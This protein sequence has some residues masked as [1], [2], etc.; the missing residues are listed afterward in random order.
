MPHRQRTAR[1]SAS[2][3]S[4]CCRCPCPPSPACATA[5]GAERVRG[6]TADQQVSGAGADAECDGGWRLCG[7]VRRRATTNHVLQRHGEQLARHGCER[8]CRR[9]RQAPH[10]HE[11]RRRRPRHAALRVDVVQ[12]AVDLL[13]DDADCGG[14]RRGAQSGKHAMCGMAAVNRDKYTYAGRRWSPQI[15]T[16]AAA[17]AAAAC[18]CALR[19]T[20]D[21]LDFSRLQQAEVRLD[22][23]A[24]GLIRLD[25]DA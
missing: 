3:G 23:V 18:E 20:A 21:H 22:G 7:H 17:A 14:A 15:F 6:S 10:L 19:R 13:L 16:R 8:L 25:L 24:L 12:E 5:R 11:E 1:G 9:G 2:A 4:C